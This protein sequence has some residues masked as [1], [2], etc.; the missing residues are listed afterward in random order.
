M[1]RLASL[2][3]R[4]RADSVLAREN[5]FEDVRHLRERWDYVSKEG[6]RGSEGIIAMAPLR[7]V[8]AIDH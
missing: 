8:F 4:E 6:Q 3:K 2:K 7:D 1:I 5:S